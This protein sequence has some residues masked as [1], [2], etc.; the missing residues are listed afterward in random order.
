MEYRARA[1]IRRWAMIGLCLML[2]GA[3]AALAVWQIERRAWKHALI[4]RVQAR[5]HAAPQPFPPRA[6]WPTLNRGDDEYRSVR[7]RGV[8]VHGS[9]T[10]IQAVTDLGAGW[11][12][13]T[14]LRT[15]GGV[16]LVNRGFVPPERA[17]PGS[18]RVPAGVVTITGLIRMSE[19]GG[20]FLHANAPAAGRWYSRDV[21][22]IARARG[23]GEVAPVFIDADETANPG[24]Y[25]VGGLTVLAFSDNHLVY[26]ITWS[27]LA[28]LALAGAVVWA[29]YDGSTAPPL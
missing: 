5:A 19:P 21:A 4:A 6:A 7:V 8:F 15:A 3:F 11:W 1:T 13:L 12:V 23:L 9:E 2:A 26:A 29:R 18:R 14:P 17:E 16:V 10:L 25:P 24:G 27:A 20:G 22:A 28:L